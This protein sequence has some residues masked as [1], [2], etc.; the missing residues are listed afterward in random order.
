MNYEYDVA[1]SFAGEDRKFVED[2][3]E[4]LRALNINVFYDNYEKEVLLGKNLY[5]YLAD[6]YQ[7]KARFAVVFVSESYKKK[8]WTNHELEY[9]TARKFTQDEEYLLP[10][11]L[12]ETELNEIPLTTGYLQGNS[13]LEV[14]IT[15]AKKINGNL[16]IDAM[17]SE[18]KY[19]LPNYEIEIIG[20]KVSF[21]CE[22]ENFYDEYPI[23]FIMELYRQD[24]LEKA[25]VLPAI[26]PN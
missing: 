11:K 8:R 6:V 22:E 25:F 20:N 10:V 23:G 15:I 14:A 16:D 2:C 4:I 9:I 5:S 1:L 21:K 18:L 19:Y 13:P 12:D 3:A 26:V 24:L 7:N 17:L